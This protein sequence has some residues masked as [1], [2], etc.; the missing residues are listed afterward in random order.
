MVALLSW[1]RLLAHG[2]LSSEGEVVHHGPLMPG[3]NAGWANKLFLALQFFMAC[4]VLGIAARRRCSHVASWTSFAS[5]PRRRSLYADHAGSAHLH[6]GCPIRQGNDV[7]W[8]PGEHLPLV[9]PKAFDGS[10]TPGLPRFLE[11]IERM[12][13]QDVDRSEML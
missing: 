1:I 13:F 10:A 2:L 5:D 6:L 8:L 7:R 12:D 4:E 3:L 9:A 11:S